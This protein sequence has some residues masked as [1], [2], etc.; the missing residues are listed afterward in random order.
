M[1]DF[2]IEKFDLK[3]VE[4]TS[5]IHSRVSDGWSKN[6]LVSDIANDSTQSFVAVADGH[7]A[8]FCSYLV[9]DDA[10]LLFVCTHPDKRKQGIAEKLLTESMALLPPA[11]SS[12]VLEV[13]SRN[14]AA[15][16][17]Y[18]KLGF[19]KLGVRKNFYSFPKDDAIVMEYNKDSIKA[20]N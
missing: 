4:E 11:V 15:L 10:E 18:N 16:A 19:E 7:V 12:I 17:L 2:T 1:T 14:T 9:T 20:M 5:E 3:H 8:A 13:R 6:S